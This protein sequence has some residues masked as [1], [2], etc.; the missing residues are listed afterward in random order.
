MGRICLAGGREGR[1]RGL[2]IAQQ[3]GGGGVQ[4]PRLA[5][6]ES[7]RILAEG[8]DVGLLAGGEL[9]GARNDLGQDHLTAEVHPDVDVP[10]AGK[11]GLQIL[12]GEDR[13]LAPE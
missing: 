5:E 9:N 7:F 4:L 1:V 6:D 11:S 10:D 2:G 3:V 12:L 13:A 8:G